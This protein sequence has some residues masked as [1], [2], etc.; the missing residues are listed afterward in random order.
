M[1]SFISSSVSSFSPEM[2]TSWNKDL[3]FLSSVPPYNKINTCVFGCVCVFMCVNCEET[4]SLQWI[5]RLKKKMRLKKTDTRLIHKYYRTRLPDNIFF[6][7]IYPIL[8]LKHSKFW[9]WLNSVKKKKK[10]VITLFIAWLLSDWLI[11][12]NFL[13]CLFLIYF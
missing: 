10:M 13:N 12:L 11:C 9:R 3:R 6:L 5:L 2:L 4:V 1:C 7:I 8:I